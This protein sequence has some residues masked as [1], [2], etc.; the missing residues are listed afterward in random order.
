MTYEKSTSLPAFPRQS[1]FVA[2]PLA[3]GRRRSRGHGFSLLELTVV[4]GIIMVLLTL[5]VVGYRYLEASASRNRTRTVLHDLE[6]MT[7][8][9]DRTGGMVRLVGPAGSGAWYTPTETL[10][11][12]GNVNNPLGGQFKGCQLCDIALVILNQ[13][14][15]NQQAISQLPAKALVAGINATQTITVPRVVPGGTIPAKL[16]ATAIADA[17]GNPVIFVP[18]GGLAGVKLGARRLQRHHH[19][20][21]DPCH[22]YCPRPSRV[23]GIRR[24]ERRFQHRRRQHL[25]V[26]EMIQG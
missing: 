15:A 8:E 22:H 4:I 5:S 3:P 24:A 12:P 14:P 6:G 18:P 21:P 19:L 11:A 13:V 7:A 20:Q 1:L 25:L 26:R 17:W 16:Q 9:L 10:P 2:G 23:L